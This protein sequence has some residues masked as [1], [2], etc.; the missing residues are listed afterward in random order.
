MT[1]GNRSIHYTVRSP[2]CYPMLMPKTKAYPRAQ[3]K[4]SCLH[5]LPH[6][7]ATPTPT[8]PLW[9]GAMIFLVGKTSRIT[10]IQICALEIEHDRLSWHT[11]LFPRHVTPVE[12][13]I[14]LQRHIL[15]VIPSTTVDLE[16]EEIWL[17]LAVFYRIPMSTDILELEPD[18]WAGRRLIMNRNIHQLRLDASFRDAMIRCRIAVNHSFLPT[19]IRRKV[20]LERR[21]PPVRPEEVSPVFRIMALAEFHIVHGEHIGTES[22]DVGLGRVLLL[23]FD[24]ARA[25]TAVN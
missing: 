10:S 5:E 22:L 8:S 24:V 18:C 14:G 19:Q 2:R 25:P 6:S 9:P 1:P 12:V 7:N 23:A 17:A 21:T 16:D 3:K 13:P 11:K 20:L 15:L 4:W